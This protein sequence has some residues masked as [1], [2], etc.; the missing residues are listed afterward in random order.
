MTQDDLSSCGAD[1]GDIDNLIDVVRLAKEADVAL[2]AKVHSDGSVKM[3]LRSRGDTDVGSL[4][5]DYGG[6][7]HRLAAGFTIR[8]EVDKVV[9]DLLSRVEDYR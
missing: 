7:G 5:A 9:E 8:N 2:L 4:A 1:W 6:G 3:S